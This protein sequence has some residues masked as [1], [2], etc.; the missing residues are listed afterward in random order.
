MVL[1]RAASDKPFIVGGFELPGIY[2][3]RRDAGERVLAIN[4]PA[5]ESELRYRSADELGAVLRDVTW[6]AATSWHEL[7]NHLVGVRQGRPLWPL[8]LAFAFFLAVSEELFANLR[9][10]ASVLP[11][12]L[13]Q[14]IKRGGRAA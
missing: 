14:F 8:L 13:R 12:A 4:I 5:E 10:R 9:S 7:Q 1:S 11:E 3:L 2:T 6:Y